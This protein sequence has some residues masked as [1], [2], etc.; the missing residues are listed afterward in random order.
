MCLRGVVKAGILSLL[1][2]FGI[3]VAQI[4]QPA[5]MPVPAPTPGQMPQPGQPS[6]NPGDAGQPPAPQ[7]NNGQQKNGQQNM[8]RDNGDQR[9]RYQ[10]AGFMGGWCA[11]GTRQSRRRSATTGRSIT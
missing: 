7:D 4:P 10:N 11:Q 8:G 3:A 9:N 1:A 5:P 2:G 6:L